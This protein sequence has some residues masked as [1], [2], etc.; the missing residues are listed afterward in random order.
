MLNSRQRAQLRGMA[1][2][3]ETIFQ[4]GKSGILE[5][6]VKQVKDAL[7]ARELIKLRILET[8]PTTVRQTADLLAEATDSDVVQVIGSKFILYKE[9]RNN[10]TIKLVK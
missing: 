5:T 8:C 7:E 3:Y 6:T 4:I 10:K 1:N 2:D 9:S